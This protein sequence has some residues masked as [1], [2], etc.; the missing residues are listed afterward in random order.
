MAFSINT[1]NASLE[2]LTSL[3][4]TNASLTMAEN[5]VS[6]GKKV[7]SAS[8]DPAIYAIS[9]TMNAQI[10]ELSGV[11]SGLQV[12]A[13][14]IST[15]ATQ[16]TSSSTLL[17][18]L[19]STLTEGQ[20]EGLSAETLDETI[21]KTLAQVDANANGATFQGVNLLAGAV[22]N[23]VT[24]TTASSVQDLT[25]TS[26]Q[27]GGFNATSAGLGLDGLNVSQAGLKIDLGGSSGTTLAGA[28]STAGADATAA[29][30]TLST[31]SANTATGS[32]Q[33]IANTTQFVLND[34]QA[35]PTTTLQANVQTA[36][37]TVA[38]G[39]TITLAK[40]GSITAA[41]ASTGAGSTVSEATNA[42][43]DKVYTFSTPG[44]S[45]TT[46][47]QSTDANGNVSLTVS[48]ATDANGNTTAEKTFVS[49]NLGTTTAKMSYAQVTSDLS[50][51][52]SNQGFGVSEDSASGD[53]LVAGGNLYTG[54][55]TGAA[56][57]TNITASTGNTVFSTESGSQ[58]AVLAV[59]AA[60]TQLNTI[61]SAL[62]SS[63]DE[64]T[65]LQNTVS[66][67]S[68]ALTSGVGALTDA[69]LSAESAQL[70]SL[71]TKQ[72]LA[73]QALSIANSQ[74]QSLLS[75]FR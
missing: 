25:G 9:Q 37:Q 53:L 73:I 59:N 1:N 47:T 12:T 22:G 36:L 27:Q 40:D 42:A 10:S 62:G 32:A 16:A 14:V 58:Y 48:T 50:T 31:T 70:T 8:D 6:T 35:L 24:S 20:T 30:I 28:G 17:S 21:T 75:L 60:I 61:S 69:D 13:Q 64:V 29:T 38:A 55:G 65:G 71:Q 45:P 57:D 44:S 19:A 43:G 7:N 4:Q 74:S 66:A 54:S 2:A 72:S 41:T 52:M 26:F 34:N 56:A 51:A 33:D 15:A 46:L 39:A 3:R 67:L 11:T 49:V 18:T 68:S 63:S 23:G 5:E